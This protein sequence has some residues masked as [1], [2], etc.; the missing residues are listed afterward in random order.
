M[1]PEKSIRTSIT[2]HGALFFVAQ[3]SLL[4]VVTLAYRMGWPRFALFLGISAAYHGLLTGLLVMRST[5]FRVESTGT[6]LLRVNLPNTLTLGRLSSL[7]SILYLIIQASTYS[8]VPVILPLMTI[9]FATDFLDGMIARRRKQITFVGRYL[10]ST[11]D[12]LMIVAVSIIF[13]YYD[14]VPL[15]FFILILCRLILFAAGMALLA[16]RSGKTDPQATFLGKASI[17]ALMVLYVMKVAG[18][19]GVPWIGDDTVIRIVEYGVALIVV[20]S[21]VDKAIFLRAKFA[22]A[23]RIRKTPSARGSA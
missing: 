8:V 6:Q 11:S 5:D 23:A 22:E 7:P 19:I 12:Y 4:I 2:L 13:Y 20:V 21:L 1:L 10:D 18:M 16:L 14:L 3:A 9:V 15:W 17:F